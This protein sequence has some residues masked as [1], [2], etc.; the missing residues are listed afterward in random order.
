MAFDTWHPA[1]LVEAHWS[2]NAVNPWT[3]ETLLKL[4][5][6]EAWLS[7]ELSEQQIRSLAVRS[8]LPLGT[9]V[10][11]RQELMVTEHCV[12]MAEGECDRNCAGCA[13]RARTR[14]LQDRKG[15]QFPI[16]TDVAGRTHVYNSVPLDLVPRLPQVIATGITGLRL[17]LHTES[18]AEV[19]AAV[20]RARRAVAMCEV[21]IDESVEPDG[22]TT[23]GHFFRGVT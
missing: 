6:T 5:A 9:A 2:L 13:R 3:L 4:G 10:Y 15:Y 23:A 1:D 19:S 11:G 14:W 7:P 20:A 18:P 21:G 12:L 22:Q 17:D 16:V 8:P